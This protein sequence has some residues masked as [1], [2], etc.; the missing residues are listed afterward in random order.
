M[1]LAASSV[2]HFVP[3]VPEGGCVMVRAWFVPA[4]LVVLRTPTVLEDLLQGVGVL[5]VVGDDEH[6]WLDDLSLV[7]AGVHLQFDLRILVDTHA[8]F[9]FQP[10]QPQDGLQFVERPWCRRFKIQ[11]PPSGSLNVACA[12]RKLHPGSA[13]RVTGVSGCYLRQ[14]DDGFWR[15]GR[16]CWLEG[17]NRSGEKRGGQET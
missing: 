12:S 15:D 11:S 16:P 5:G 3:A 1:I 2:P 6:E 14:P 10:F 9:Q 8:V 4:L 17:L 7:P 13:G